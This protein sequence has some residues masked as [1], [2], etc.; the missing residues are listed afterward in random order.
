MAAESIYF[1][2]CSSREPRK[3]KCDS[4]EIAALAHLD[5]NIK[6]HREAG[7]SAG[8]L[9]NGQWEL[10]FPNKAM[11]MYWVGDP[12]GDVQRFP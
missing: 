1:S 8:M 6:G 9:H 3:L 11:V 5:D 2:V 10:Y 12:D 4:R 7:G